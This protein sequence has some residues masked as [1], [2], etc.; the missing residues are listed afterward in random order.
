MNYLRWLITFFHICLL[1]VTFYSVTWLYSGLVFKFDCTLDY[2][3]IDSSKLTA[4]VLKF[5]QPLF[6]QTSLP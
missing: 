1:S 5:G 6:G 3:I 4:P 2:S